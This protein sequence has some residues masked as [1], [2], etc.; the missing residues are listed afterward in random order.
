MFRLSFATSSSE[1]TSPLEAGEHNLEGSVNASLS[2]SLLVQQL[3]AAQTACVS[4]PVT[5]T[6]GGPSSPLWQPPKSDAPT[7]HHL[8]IDEGTA[9][10]PSFSLGSLVDE[11]LS[12]VDAV[13]DRFMADEAARSAQL[14]AIMD[15]HIV[16]L[17]CFDPA[18]VC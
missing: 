12:S 4:A 15:N 18:S 7:Q 3:S 16:A 2:A 1:S 9:L 13:V 11:D 17:K 6:A 14:G 10:K 5:A 8:P